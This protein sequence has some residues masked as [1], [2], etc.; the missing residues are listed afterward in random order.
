MQQGHVRA[1]RGQH[2]QPGHGLGVPALAGPRPDHRRQRPHGLVVAD[3]PL[4]GQH[5]PVLGWCPVG[6]PGLEHRPREPRQRRRVAQLPHHVHTRVH[7]VGLGH[8]QHRQHVPRGGAGQRV[9]PVAQQDPGQQHRVGPGTHHR[10]LRGQP[11]QR[12][13]G[14]QVLD[15]ARDPLAVL[16]R[17]LAQ[18][19][20]MPAPGDQPQRRLGVPPRLARLAERG[21]QQRAGRGLRVPQ[22]P[23]DRDRVHRLQPRQP[24]RQQHRDL[25]VDERQ[26][27]LG[28]PR[29]VRLRDLERDRVRVDPEPGDHRLRPVHRR[30]HLRVPLAEAVPDQVLRRLEDQR[31]LLVVRDPAL[32][33]PVDRDPP[34]QELRVGPVVPAERLRPHLPLTRLPPDV[35]RDGRVQPF[36]D[37]RLHDRALDRPRGSD[38]QRRQRIGG[39]VG[40]RPLLGHQR[41]VGLDV[42][43][44]QH[45]R[46]L[47]ARHA[48]QLPHRPRGVAL[49]RGEHGGPH[50]LVVQPV[51][52]QP[53]RLVG[54]DPRQCLDDE[55][56]RVAVVV[57]VEQPRQDGRDAHSHG[58]DHRGQDVLLGD[59]VPVLVPRGHRRH[60]LDGPQGGEEQPVL[61]DGP[62]LGH[63]AV[64]QLVDPV[65]PGRREVG[66]DRPRQ[67]GLPAG[68]QRVDGGEVVL[69]ARPD[70]QPAQSFDDLAVGVRP[71][72]ALDGAPLHL[73]RFPAA[74]AGPGD[75]DPAEVPG[76]RGGEGEPVPDHP[77]VRDRGHVLA[78]VEPRGLLGQRGRHRRCAQRSRV[79]FEVGAR[80]GHE[81]RLGVRV[82]EHRAQPPRYRVELGLQVLLD[83]ASGLERSARA[84]SAARSHGVAPR[85]RD[86]ERRLVRTVDGRLPDGRLFGGRL[87]GGRL[88]GGRR[89]VHRGLAAGRRG[90]PADLRVPLL[91]LLRHQLADVRHRRRVRREV[92]DLGLPRRPQPPVAHCHARAVPA[93][94]PELRGAIR[95]EFPPAHV[96]LL[97]FGPTGEH[98]RGRVRQ[99]PE[100]PPARHRPNGG[101][102]D[103][104]AGGPAG[105]SDRGPRRWEVLPATAERSPP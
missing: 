55:L 82:G 74:G 61:L 35:A 38:Q 31:G 53:E 39:R 99:F 64:D 49:D 69:L 80:R 2:G 30:P 15:R 48:R 72:L 4:R 18:H 103:L 104:N 43:D 1:D 37:D 60:L 87:F 24:V 59:V 8:R 88:F 63:H 6:L 75:L 84:L 93:D 12:V 36:H 89:R 3:Q 71:P 23:G 28:G 10:H 13:G 44:E 96:Q 94:L 73:R 91:L 100:R 98:G 51:E 26:Q 19:V 9:P 57:V 70:Q 41:R 77:R 25:A 102:A 65:V 66:G 16:G 105:R 21:G 27:H 92:L 97:R 95:H 45:P 101:R 90:G 62:G 32:E 20:G 67:Q 5:P 46:R 40:H 54:R 34:D 52:Q 81:L 56:A 17:D 11:V 47:R 68:G 79:T 86:H 85:R 7:V 42:P 50:E 29:R 78:A 58:V 76:R 14:D 83:A 33:H 22:E